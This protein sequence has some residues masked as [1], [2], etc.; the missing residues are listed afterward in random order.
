MYAI[1]RDAIVIGIKKTMKNK[2]VDFYN[3]LLL[4]KRAL[5][6]TAASN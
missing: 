5:I 3:K 1:E 4:W 6:E 2:L